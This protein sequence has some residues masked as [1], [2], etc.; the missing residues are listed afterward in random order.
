VFII[1]FNLQAGHWQLITL[2]IFLNT[3]VCTEQKI[4]G[5][6]LD[7]DGRICLQI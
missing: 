1:E 5:I 2:G 4:I 7:F 6:V 3:A